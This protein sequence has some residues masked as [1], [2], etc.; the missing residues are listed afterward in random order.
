MHIIA[1]T[2]A[3]RAPNPGGDHAEGQGKPWHRTRDGE[4]AM[5]TTDPIFNKPT[6]STLRY[7][8][9]GHERDPAAF[10]LADTNRNVPPG[11]IVRLVKAGLL[12]R[13]DRPG[14]FDLFRITAEGLRLLGEQYQD[15]DAWEHRPAISLAWNAELAG[16]HLDNLAE[17]A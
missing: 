15:R 10:W 5:P 2:R 8:R 17:I 1:L 6:I 4:D 13:C 9:R 14:S 11:R 12:E 16:R 3:E 7:F